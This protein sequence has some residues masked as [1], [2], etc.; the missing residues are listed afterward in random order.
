MGIEALLSTQIIDTTTVGRA[1]MT[2]ADAAAALSAIGAVPT[3]RQLTING[4]A[5]DLSADRSWTV[6]GGIS[7]LNALTDATQTFAVG[8]VGTDFAIVSES[9]VHTFNLPDASATNRGLVTTGTQ[10]I[11]GQKTIASQNAAHVA[12]AVQAAASPTAYLQEW[13]QSTGAVI[14]YVEQFTSGSVRSRVSFDTYRMN[15]NGSAAAGCLYGGPGALFFTQNATKMMYYGQGGNMVLF[16]NYAPGL[17]SLGGIGFSNTQATMAIGGQILLDATNHLVQR[18][19]TNQQRWSLANTWTSSTSLEYF[20]IAWTD[21]AG[22][23]TCTLQTIAGS[24]GGVVRGMRIGASSAQ[25]LSFYGATPVDQPAT[26]A[27]PTGGSTIDAEA[28]TAIQTII[29]RL[30]EL[31]LIA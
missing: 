18:N 21:V 22:V 8:T 2:A 24:A 12:L 17:I 20:D 27:D 30:Q 15:Q 28:R 13:R 23:P 26:V 14:G 4:T 9:G 5:Y 16:N 10:T 29:D 31:G 1:V 7:S 19:G 11:A 3:T 25:L 6:S